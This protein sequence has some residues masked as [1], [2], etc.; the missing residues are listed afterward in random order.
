MPHDENSSP[1]RGVTSDAPNADDQTGIRIGLA[2]QVLGGHLAEHFRVRRKLTPAQRAAAG[3]RIVSILDG[4]GD[5]I[6]TLKI[7]IRAMT[8]RDLG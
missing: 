5:D 7:G 2:I 4:I 8:R 6:D 3:A 1:I